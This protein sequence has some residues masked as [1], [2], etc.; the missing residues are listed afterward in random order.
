MN[1]EQFTVAVEVLAISHAKYEIVYSVHR[2]DYAHAKAMHIW[3]V[4]LI[5]SFINPN[6][7]TPRANKFKIS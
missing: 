6:A 4:E 7:P 1:F 2:T 5:F 3:Y